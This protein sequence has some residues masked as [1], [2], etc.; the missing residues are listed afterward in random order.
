MKTIVCDIQLFDMN[1]VI[2]AIDAKGTTYFAVSSSL[3]DLSNDIVDLCLREHITKV[4]LFGSE[5]YLNKSILP[6]ILEYSK[7]HY[8]LNNIEVEIN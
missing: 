2:S 1:Q 7:S 5:D 4:H 3:D 6:D 8:E